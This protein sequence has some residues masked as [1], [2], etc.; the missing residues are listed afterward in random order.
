MSAA[1]SEPNYHEEYTRSAPAGEV[2]NNYHGDNGSNHPKKI[3]RLFK[4]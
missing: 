2:K 3:G 1:S 4:N